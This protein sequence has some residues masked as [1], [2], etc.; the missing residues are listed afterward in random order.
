M[1]ALRVHDDIATGASQ[2]ETAAALLSDAAAEARW[3]L[4]ASSVRSQVQQLARAACGLADG[5]YQAF[6]R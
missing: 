4:H 2:R 3:R 1:L 5:G 6:L